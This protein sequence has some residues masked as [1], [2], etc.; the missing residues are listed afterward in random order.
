MAKNTGEKSTRKNLRQQSNRNT[1]VS[2]FLF[3]I[4]IGTVS[5]SYYSA[6]LGTQN[7]RTLYSDQVSLEQFRASL[8]NVMLP[9]ND[10]VLTSSKDD[11]D[12]LA[13]ASV[14]FRK[15][16]SDVSALPSMT[17]DKVKQLK[18]VFDLIQQVEGIASDILS[19][20]IPFDQAKNMSLVAQSMV[21]VAQAKVNKVANDLKKSLDQKTADTQ[22]QMTTLA[23]VN[24]AIIV[25]L[26]LLL[27]INSRRF[28]RS[29]T[30]T[31]SDIAQHVTSASG[32]ILSTVDQQVTA[33][34]TQA[35]SVSAI[36]QELEQMSAAAK[37]IAATAASVE[38]IADATMTSADQ[39]G[40][41][42]GEAIGFLNNV[43]NE[44][45]AISEK[46]NFARQKAEQIL[47]SVESV[48]DIAD[49]THLLAL[50]ASIESA[51]AGEFGKRFAVVAAEVRRLSER[52]RE[53]TEEIETVVNEVNTSTLE[54]ME[55]T[56]KGLTEVEQGVLIAQRANDALDK[57]QSMSNKTSQ[58]VRTIAQATS[59]QDKASHEFLEAMQQISQLLHDSAKQMQNSRDIS[60]RLN[61][62][63]ADLQ[64]LF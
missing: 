44:V 39:G 54:S 64:K 32:D 55:V 50:N 14:K 26:L 59:R 23:A 60:R 12:R 2:V 15:L 53:F 30:N 34:D 58:A 40:K 17:L 61:E 46:V 19:G 16:Y 38:K 7:L 43:R 18:Q 57:M 52:V 47:E 24:I 25:F 29:I 33:S 56:K 4:L 22:K 31:I 5:F 49:E 42:V 37:R 21:F 41:A 6:N 1:L 36:T 8:P 51:A 9:L 28:V 11:K 62:V 20:K 10:F 3:A 13:T 27:V 48:Q 45:N 63:A 35:M